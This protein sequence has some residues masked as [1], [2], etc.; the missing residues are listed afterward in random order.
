MSQSTKRISRKK[1]TQDA[2]KQSQR[3]K[4]DK[5]LKRHS[6]T[7]RHLLDNGGAKADIEAVLNAMQIESGDDDHHN[8][9][10]A[11]ADVNSST[12]STSE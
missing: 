12:T 5:K 1:E 3:R 9:Y 2:F 7:I 11:E 6:A 10:E 4:R 8:T